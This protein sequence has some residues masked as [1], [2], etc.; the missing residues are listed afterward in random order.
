MSFVRVNNSTFIG[1]W[2]QTPSNSHYYILE[3]VDVSFEQILIH[4]QTDVNIHTF[5]SSRYFGNAVKM[6][7]IQTTALEANLCLSMEN[8]ILEKYSDA[9]LWGQNLLW[10]LLFLA[11]GKLCR[12]STVNSRKL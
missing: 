7:E 6:V 10:T 1:K 12:G 11:K 9:V 2:Q 3:N 8:F 4:F 5:T